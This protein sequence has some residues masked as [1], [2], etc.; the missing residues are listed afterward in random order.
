MAEDFVLRVKEVH[1]ACRHD[2]LSEFLA[3]PDNRPV[4][5]AQFFLVL[6]KPLV[7]HE[8][9]VADGLNLQKVIEACDTL[10]FCPAFVVQDCLKQFARLA[11][12]AD[13]QALT[14]LQ[15]FGL[16]HNGHAL[17][18]FEIAIGNQPVEIAQA[19][20]VFRKDDDVPRAAVEDLAAGAQ[21]LHARVDLLQRVQSLLLHH[22]EKAH[23]QI[24][25]GDRVVGGAVM[26]EIRQAQRI[27]D[28]VELVLAKLRHQVLRQ[29]ERVDIRRVERQAELFARRR[30]EADVKI[31]VVRAQG[32][33]AD[34]F[35]EFRHC[36]G[37]IRL[38]GKHLV[39]DA[40]QID[41]LRL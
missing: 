10:E 35:Q 20:G 12:R 1:I 27:G 39:V 33:A 21:L 38:P 31:R 15:Q 11:G 28:N 7:E 22:L 19:D 6:G 17:E 37:N 5:A 2:R 32:A 41:D 25:A 4:E 29:N 34:V 30:H 14:P 8:A 26:V 23:E 18:V 3:E 40:R 16:R 36:L 9:V 24:P 13:N